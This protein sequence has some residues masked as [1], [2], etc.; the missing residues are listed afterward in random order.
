M[1]YD[2]FRSKS[3][4]NHTCPYVDA[5]SVK[6]SNLECES[7]NQSWII[8]H[9][10]RLKA[11]NRKR[12]DVNFNSTI[13]HPVNILHVHCQVLKKANGYKP[14]LIDYTVDGCAFLRKNNHPFVKIVYDLFKSKSNINHTCPYGPIIVKDLYLTP[15]SIPLPFPT[16]DYCLLLEWKFDR[17]IQIITK[18]CMEYIEDN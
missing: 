18:Y 9:T 5:I 1:I 2:L 10:C 17:R 13:L 11:I 6:F 3:N 7:K 4:I 8:V 14:W 16:G 12:V 15:N